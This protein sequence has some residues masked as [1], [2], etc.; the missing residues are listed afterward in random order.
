M[1]YGGKNNLVP[2]RKYYA[3]LQVYSDESGWSEVRTKEFFMP[4]SD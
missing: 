4:K 3:N 2:G 1:Y